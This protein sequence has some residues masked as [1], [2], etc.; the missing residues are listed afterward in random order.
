MFEKPKYKKAETKFLFPDELVRFR[1]GAVKR[2]EG[3]FI[4]VELMLDTMLRVSELVN[5]DVSDVEG[6]DGAGRYSLHVTVKGGARKSMP[7]S[8]EVF[9]AVQAYLAGR[10][11]LKPSAPLLANRDGQRW[12]RSALTQVVGRIAKLAGVTRFSVSAHK[13]RHTAATVA[14]AAGVNPLA[15]SRL[16]NHASMRTTEQ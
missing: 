3:E 16:L 4:A 11:P 2:P 7:V 5:A 8:P 14:L 15:V 1:A 10:A 13:L 12:T 6:P 9:G